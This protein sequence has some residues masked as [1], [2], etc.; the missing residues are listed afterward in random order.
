MA[1]G[2]IKI[3]FD[4]FLIKK[5]HCISAFSISDSLDLVQLKYSMN[6]FCLQLETNHV[7]N[8]LAASI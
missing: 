6:T 1:N 7:F 4:T 8:R 3:I 2:N 5:N